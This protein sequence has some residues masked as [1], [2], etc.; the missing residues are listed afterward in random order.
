MTFPLLSGEFETAARTADGSK[1]S[2]L[3][4]RGVSVAEKGPRHKYGLNMRV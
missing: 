4:P 3:V 1:K 2:E